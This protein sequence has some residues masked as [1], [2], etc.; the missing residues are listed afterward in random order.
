MA[1]ECREC[2]SRLDDFLTGDLPREQSEKLKSH[3]T[4]CKDCRENLA[5]RSLP[6]NE[7]HPQESLDL[8]AGILART[9]GSAC[10]RAHELLGDESDGALS[11]LDREL[12]RSHLGHC[13]DCEALAA[14][15]AWSGDLLPTMAE[16]D[17]DPAFLADVM[18]VTS[19]LENAAAPDP[20][21][22]RLAEWWQRL[23]RRPRI[24]L[25]L[26][27]LGTM[28]LILLFALPFSPG[29][30]APSRALDAIGNGTNAV[31]ASLTPNLGSLHEGL[32][33]QGS[34]IRSWSD[35]YLVPELQAI[36]TEL[37]ERGTRVKTVALELRQHSGALIDAA[38]QG[39][40]GESVA[41]LTAIGGD[42]AKLWRGILGMD[43]A[44][45]NLI[46]ETGATDE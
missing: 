30:N 28:L 5:A 20:L 3:L 19:E 41:G 42:L 37:D 38:L 32:A 16:V 22:E 24:S 25:E 9:S 31:S 45:T 15:M 35:E 43:S 36:G 17:P 27:Y 23:Y 34:R 7:L 18:R 13:C 2:R 39:K 33:Q 29:K 44:P 11:E 12:L 40:A 1:N 46:T 6:T 10:D 21:R 26:A 14:A 4:G 8:T